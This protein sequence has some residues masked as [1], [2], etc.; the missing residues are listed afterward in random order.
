[1]RISQTSKRDRHCNTA[2]PHFEI[3]VWELPLSATIPFVCYYFLL[4]LFRLCTW[5]VIISYTVCSVV[6][7]GVLA[8]IGTGYASTF[9]TIQSY[10]QALRVPYILATP[11]RPSALDGYQYDVSVCPPYVEALMKVT[12][13]LTRSNN[14]IFY[15]Y[16]SDDGKLCVFWVL[17]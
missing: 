5:Q 6:N 12:A 4:L 1:M 14:T 2:A 17:I 3:F 8:I 15:V 9:N 11:S 13:N 10:C 16:D 7:D